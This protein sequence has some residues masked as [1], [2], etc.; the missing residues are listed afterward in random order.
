MIS[1]AIEGFDWDKIFSDKN[2]DE[3]ASTLTQAILN[4]TCNFI[5]NNQY[6]SN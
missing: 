3:K 1:K 4:I 6:I 2:T 5:P